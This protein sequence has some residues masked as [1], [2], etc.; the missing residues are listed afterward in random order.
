M[1][2]NLTEADKVYV[3]KIAEMSATISRQQDEIEYLRRTRGDESQPRWIR[4]EKTNELSER[5][6]DGSYRVAYMLM[7]IK[8]PTE[9]RDR[10]PNR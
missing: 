3:R 2:L 8:E 6:S 7:P 1:K 9:L 10:A 4:D 5:Q